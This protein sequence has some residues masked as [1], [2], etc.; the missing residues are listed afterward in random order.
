MCQISFIN[1]GHRRSIRSCDYNYTDTLSLHLVPSPFHLLL[2]FSSSSLSLFHFLPTE[3]ILTHANIMTPK[4]LTSICCAK[5]YSPPSQ[6]CN[7]HLNSCGH[8]LCSHHIRNPCAIC[9]SSSFPTASRLQT[10]SSL[11]LSFLHILE[12]LHTV[13]R[14]QYR[15]LVDLVS[16]QTSVITRLN[17]K[18]SNQ[19]RLIATA[20]PNLVKLKEYKA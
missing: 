15:R 2:F 3:L 10:I 9:K 16:H 20:K 19:R 8:I 7:L 14:F 18:V 12:T 11:S 5:C 13:A 17:A 4:S 1:T 6:Q